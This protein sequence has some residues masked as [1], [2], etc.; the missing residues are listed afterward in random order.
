MQKTILHTIYQ[1]NQETLDLKTLTKSSP[2]N[3]ELNF[4]FGIAE[5]DAFNFLDKEE[6][7]RFFKSLEDELKE[8]LRVLDF[9]CA[10]RYH[11]ITPDGKRKPLKFDYALLRFA[12]QRRTM[13]LFIVHERG[14]QR[15]PLE[16][17]A[18]FL[19]NRIKNELKQRELKTLTLKHMHAL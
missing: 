4:E 2:A 16:D 15:I 14:T 17:L 6:S 5:Q 7:E 18:I 12:F 3:C 1:L 11:T 10:T 8:Q 13:E 19:T 9:F